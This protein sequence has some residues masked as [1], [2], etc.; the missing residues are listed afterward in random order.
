V[1][2]IRLNPEQLTQAVAVALMAEQ[3]AQA[4]SSSK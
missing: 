4:L 1:A 3:A 2:V